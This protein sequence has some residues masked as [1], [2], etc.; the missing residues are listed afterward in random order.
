MCQLFTKSTVALKQLLVSLSTAATYMQVANASLTRQLDQTMA[1]A[2][3]TGNGTGR[4]Q[5]IF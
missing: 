5:T 1:A 4:K 3:A 2:N